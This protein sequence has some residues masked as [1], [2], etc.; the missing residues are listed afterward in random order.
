M[1][2]KINFQER[3]VQFLLAGVKFEQ[4]AQAA[5]VSKPTVEHWIQGD[6]EPYF[7]RQLIILDKLRLLLRK[8]K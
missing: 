2:Y 8:E 6:G 1:S 7:S 4:I 3:I 5:G